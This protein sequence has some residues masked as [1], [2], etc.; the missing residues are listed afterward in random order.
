MKTNLSLSE[1]NMM[2]LKESGKS[3]A[4][5]CFSA[6]PIVGPALDEMAFEGRSRMYQN[7]LNRFIELLKEYMSSVQEKDID[8]RYLKSDEFGDIFESIIRKVL[9]TGSEEKI[10]R[11]KMILVQDMKNTYHSDFKE[12][13]L[14]IASKIN[15]DQIIILNEYRKFREGGSSEED[16]IPKRNVIDG[17][18]I[19]DSEPAKIS[20]HRLP[21]HYN[22]EQSKYI[23]YIQDLIS[24]SLIFDD[25][26]GRVG[27]RPFDILDITDF[28][29]EFLN[30][31]EGYDTKTDSIT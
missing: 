15:E 25:G 23:F 14:D 7:R 8:F 20:F 1:D 3:V 21:E 30:Y 9:L 4:K 16:E 12:T 26:I 13:Y 18:T 22:L 17:G 11:F 28:G 6:I 10:N 24:K 2:V 19:G 5:V 29:C 27:T 31:I